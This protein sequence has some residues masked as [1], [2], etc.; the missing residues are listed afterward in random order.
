MPLELKKMLMLSEIRIMAREIGIER[1]EQKGGRIRLFFKQEAPLLE[2]LTGLLQ[3]QG[4]DSEP[5]NREGIQI[6]L[7]RTG[8]RSVLGSLKKA[9][10]ALSVRDTIQKKGEVN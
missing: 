5:F 10:Q 7:S 2:E 3:K 8:W 6:N 1:A 4:L 9:L